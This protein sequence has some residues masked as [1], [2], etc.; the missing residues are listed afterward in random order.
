MFTSNSKTPKV[1]HQVIEQIKNN[2]KS[3]KLKKGR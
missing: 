3:G 1:Y 2:I